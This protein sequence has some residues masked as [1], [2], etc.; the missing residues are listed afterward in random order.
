MLDIAGVALTEDDRRRLSHPLVGGLILFSRN[1]DNPEQLARLTAD[2]HTLRAPHL[3]IAADQEGGRVQRFRD[4]FTRIP[5]MRAIG[6]V[7]DEHPGRARRLAHD[8]GFVLGAELRA[9]GVDL[10]FAPVLDL[11]WGASTVIGD[12][13]LHRDPDV[14]S[15][16]ALAL[17]QG[18]KDAGMAAC[19]K[20]FPGH[21]FVVADSHV[22]TPVD[23]RDF[24]D[25]A[26]ADLVPFR[27]LAQNGLASIMPAHVVY[28]RVDPRPAG[29]SSRWLTDVLRRELGF[30][31]VIFSDD[32]AMEGAAV[33]GGIADRARAALDA[34]C[35]MVLVC[36]REDLA[37]ELLSG[38]RP[39]M[40][41]V[42]AA[43]LIRMHGRSHPPSM[44]ELRENPGYVHAVHD[45]G[46]LVPA[47]GDL[48]LDPTDVCA[49]R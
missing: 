34:G 16:L 18:L 21:G 48:A 26:L 19:G 40:S 24:A 20:H 25:I 47:S 22:A 33:A 42:S 46:T 44:T 7:W 30:E 6:R 35:D 14:V 15:E 37:D 38:L 27:R 49:R 13:A 8:A 41:P 32:L 5:P 11:D 43:R 39:V 36:N 31:G 23:E 4:G 17:M 9:H 2:V 3:V 12:R 29:F 45:L 10:S 28:P 1:F